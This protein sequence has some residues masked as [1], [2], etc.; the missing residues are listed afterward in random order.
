MT[1]A[2]GPLQAA[3]RELLPDALR[4]FA[5][6][7]ILIV[8]IMSFAGGLSGSSMGGFNA[9][10]TVADWMVVALVAFLAEFKFYPIFSF[11]FGYG[12][13]LFWRKARQRGAD[14]G[15]L[16]NRRIGFM[17]VLGIL[18]GVFI[19]FGD[20]LSRYA[21]V[22]LLLKGRLNYGPKRLLLSMRRWLIAT[23]LVA[24]ALSLSMVASTLAVSVLDT[25]MQQDGLM[26]ES[27]EATRQIYAAGGY[28]AITWQRLIDYC[29][30]TAVFI[31]LIPQVMFLF[32]CGAFIARAGWLRHVERHRDKWRRI[33]RWSLYVGVPVNLLWAAMQLANAQDQSIWFPPVAALID[34]LIPV[35]AA[36]YVAVFA[37]LSGHERSAGIFRLLAY[38]GRMPLT[39]YIAQSVICSFFLYGYGLGLGDDL[40][41]A[42]LALLAFGIYGA[43]LLWSRAW[44]SRYELGPLEALWRRFTY[45]ASEARKA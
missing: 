21:L 25:A 35:Q 19:W 2:S 8:N 12:F 45:Q 38:A 1:A 17:A 26:R 13:T 24:A 3:Q 27:A 44:L 36:A 43:Q 15:A 23:V 6:F 31:F 41:Q 33:L 42:K 14:A 32:L 18:H 37:L 29:Y 30:I 40:G 39:N 10:S 20:I 4:G 11:L 5:L 34:V 7:G 28:W 16:F 22:A 9:A